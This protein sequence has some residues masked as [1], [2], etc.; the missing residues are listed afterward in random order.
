MVYYSYTGAVYF[1]PLSSDIRK[2]RR[3]VEEAHRSE[4]PD[5]PAL[6]S[7]KSIY[8]LA[9]K[10]KFPLSRRELFY[11][12][13]SRIQYD[14]TPLAELALDWFTAQLTNKVVMTELFQQHT[15]VYSQVKKVLLSYLLEHWIEMRHAML[16]RF[17]NFS[18]EEKL[19]YFWLVEAVLAR[20]TVA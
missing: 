19:K 6:V 8:R 17:A 14:I 7:C 15:E 3:Q 5:A 4:H 10:V 11:W 12:L 13:T 1:A 16:T 2:N 20:S 18:P 9:E